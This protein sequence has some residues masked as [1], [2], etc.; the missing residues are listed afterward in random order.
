[1]ASKHQVTYPEPGPGRVRCL[2]PRLPEHW[3]AND[4]K[5][6]RV[7]PRCRERINELPWRAQVPPNDHERDR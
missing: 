4:A 3:F 5:G 1:M 2:G 6:N 7:C